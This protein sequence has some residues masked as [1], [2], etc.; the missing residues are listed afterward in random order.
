MPLLFIRYDKPA[1]FSW[2]SGRWLVDGNEVSMKEAITAPEAVMEVVHLLDSVIQRSWY[3]W[4]QIT[5]QY[6][7]N[8]DG[9]PIRR[10][11]Y[12]NDTLIR[13]EFHNRE[14]FHISDEYF[15][16]DG[17]ITEQVRRIVVEGK[18]QEYSRWWYEK[19]VPVKLVGSEGHNP[20]T[21]NP[22]VYVK[23]GEWWVKKSELR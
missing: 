3:E 1:D 10:L 8:C 7:L 18:L 20:T 4:G 15:D 19:G 16:P 9:K 11:F 12:Q 23:E 2:S 5:R 22:G 21:G 14:G 13:R 6:D 17:Y